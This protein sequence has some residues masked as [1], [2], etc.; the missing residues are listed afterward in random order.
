M[1]S[2]TKQKFKIQKKSIQNQKLN[3]GNINGKKSRT[4]NY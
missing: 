2:K 1:K 4:I 3:L